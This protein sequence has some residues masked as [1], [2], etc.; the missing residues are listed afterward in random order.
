MS[1]LQ[2]LVGVVLIAA[3]IAG[4]A[5]EKPQAAPA[6]TA[7]PVVVGSDRDAHGCKASAG[8]RWCERENACVRPWELARAKGF[9]ADGDAFERYCR[10]A[11]Q[12]R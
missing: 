5:S 11:E 3:S 12:G 1:N 4:C 9:E 8:Y 10:V 2:D 6:S 7:A